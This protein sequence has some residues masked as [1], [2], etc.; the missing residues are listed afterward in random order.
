MPT[1]NDTPHDFQDSLAR[2]HAAED[3]PFWEK[4]YREAFPTMAAMVNHRKSGP[5]QRDGIDRSIIL[6]NSDQ[7]LIDEKVRGSCGKANRVYEDILLEHYSDLGARVRGW[8]CKP[9]RAQY[10]AYA[11]APLGRCYLLSV[12]LLQ[13]AW[14]QN[15][16]DWRL[17]RPR[18]YG[19]RKCLS[20]NNGRSWITA[21]V[22]VPVPVLFKAMGEAT[23]FS[24]DCFEYRH[25]ATG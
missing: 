7:I 5:H 16:R 6:D 15:G 21:S 20:T 25:S 17:N 12:P 22:P 14:E 11:I 3:L 4:V 2:S 1:L 9:L 24:F 18:G 19:Y 8:V 10:I 13:R 23:V